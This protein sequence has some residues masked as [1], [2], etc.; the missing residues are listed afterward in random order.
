MTRVDLE[1]AGGP[2][3][4]ETDDARPEDEDAMAHI[5]ASLNPVA[6][7]RLRERLGRRVLMEETEARVCLFQP[8]PGEL[9]RWRHE[10][11]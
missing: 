9:E 1:Y 3:L 8:E 2:F 4:P 10:R 7:E 5:Y 6:G 11:R